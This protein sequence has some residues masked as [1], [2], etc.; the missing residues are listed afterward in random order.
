M[1]D[2]DH[3]LQK[4]QRYIRG[5][6]LKLAPSPGLAEDI[7]QDV[8]VE[9]LAHAE[10]WDLS[11]DLKPLFAGITRNVARRVWR[12]RMRDASVDLR[13]LA[14][15]IREVAGETDVDWITEREKSAL[16]RCLKKLPSRSRKLLDLFYY[17]GLTSQDIAAKMGITSSTVRTSLLRVRDRLQA[18]VRHQ[19][20]MGTGVA[21][22]S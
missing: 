4:Y 12:D 3:A 15:H 19:L 18:C 1:T 6:A 20:A 11:R 22:E 13:K 2:L 17:V 9:I 5:L 10:R 7:A 14:E 21:D 16:R 8:F